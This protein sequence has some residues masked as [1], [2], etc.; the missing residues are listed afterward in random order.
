MQLNSYLKLYIFIFLIFLSGYF[1][2]Q[3]LFT[4][5]GNRKNKTIFGWVLAGTC[6]GVAGDLALI[7]F[8]LYKYP[9]ISSFIN[10]TLFA[11]FFFALPATGGIL[12]ILIYTMFFNN[13]KEK[14]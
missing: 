10:P 1:A 5:T 8:P 6:L 11:V 13:R 3:Y 4:K 2:V 14:A 12:S 7:Q 9:Q